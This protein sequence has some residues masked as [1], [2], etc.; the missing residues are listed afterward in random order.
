MLFVGANDGMLHAFDALTGVERWAYIPSQ[1]V[2]SLR[3]LTDP[4]YRHR[5]FVDGSPVVGDAY[6]DAAWK[7]VLV[8]T[9]GA[10]GRGVF[11]L[12][13]TNPDSFGTGSV[14]WEFT[15]AQDA[16]LGHVIGRASIARMANGEWAAIFGSGYGSGKAARLYI[17]NLKTG[18]EIKTLSTVHSSQEA[19]AVANGLASPLPVDLD[20]DTITDVIYAG[21]LYGN[22]W[23]FDLGGNANSW[24]VAFKQGNNPRPLFTAC[25]SGDASGPFACAAASRQ[26][27]TSRPVAGYGQGGVMVYFGTG[28]FF[29]TGDNIVDANTPKQTFYAVLDANARVAGRSALTQQ[30]ITSEATYDHDGYEYEL[31]TTSN[32]LPGANSKGWYLDVVSPNGAEGERIVASPVLREGRIIFATLIPS[33]DACDAGGSSWLMELSAAS[34]SRL[35]HTPFDANN[36]GVIDGNDGAADGTP[37]SGMRSTVG[38]IQ[39]PTIIEIPGTTNEVKISSGSEGGLMNTL[40]S[41]GATAGRTSWRQLWPD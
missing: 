3:V 7:S 28:K 5:Y 34:G 22:L 14:L 12:D 31:R 6:Y 30:T 40:E 27:I 35:P 25:A 18:A 24:D 15:D 36:D 33:G 10:G 4:R 1:L 41:R 23:K 19:S 20:G 37:G 16:N 21:D 2:P 32:T 11:A 17:R 38:I 26:P 29:E 13:V 39:T 9:L 8:G